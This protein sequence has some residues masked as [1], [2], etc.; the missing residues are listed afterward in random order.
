MVDFN[1][2]ILKITL[3]IGDLN[4]ALTK[5]IIRSGKKSST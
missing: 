4:I 2:T 3:N 1:S 5:Q